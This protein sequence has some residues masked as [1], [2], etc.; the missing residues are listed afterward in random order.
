M[1]EKRNSKGLTLYFIFN[2]LVLMTIVY[3]RIRLLDRGIVSV[4]AARRR[5]RF[6][7]EIK[8]KVKINE[9]K[10]GNCKLVIGNWD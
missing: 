6:L 3:E 9:A 2:K 1:V 5:H 4:G 7:K 10:L 8:E